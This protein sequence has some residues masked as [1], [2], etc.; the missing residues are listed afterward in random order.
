MTYLQTQ[1]H[2]YIIIINKPFLI[3]FYFESLVTQK[4]FNRSL[5]VLERSKTEVFD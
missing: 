5:V 1:Y 4:L 3:K 2:S